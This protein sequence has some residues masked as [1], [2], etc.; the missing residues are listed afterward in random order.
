MH[1]GPIRVPGVHISPRR[2]W[3]QGSLVLKHVSDSTERGSGTHPNFTPVSHDNVH[4]ATSLHSVKTKTA[5]KSGATRSSSSDQARSPQFPFPLL[6]QSNPTQATIWEEQLKMASP[7]SLSPH[8][9]ASRSPSPPHSTQKLLMTLRVSHFSL[10]PP[11]LSLGIMASQTL[12]G[13]A[14]ALQPQCSP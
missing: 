9:L 4:K 6:S 5:E 8:R 10:L 7:Q 13:T 11:L 1:H 3:F 12:L 2:F 14:A